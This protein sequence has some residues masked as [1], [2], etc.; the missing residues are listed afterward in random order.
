[1]TTGR[2]ESDPYGDSGDRGWTPRPA[3]PGW[4]AGQDYTGPL[5]DDTGWHIDL[6]DVDWGD[7][8]GSDWGDDRA[9]GAG[10]SFRF[11]N[12]DPHGGNG[13]GPATAD[14]DRAVESPDRTGQSSGRHA[15]RGRPHDEQAGLGRR[16][17]PRPPGAPRRVPG[18]PPPRA[19]PR[20]VVPSAYQQ[21]PTA[22]PR[23]FDA[24]PFDAPPYDPGP[25]DPDGF[26]PRQGFQAPPYPPRGYQ[27]PAWPPSSPPLTT[28]PVYEEPGY[29]ARRPPSARPSAGPPSGRLAGARAGAD[30]GPTSVVRSSGV[31]A[32]GTLGSRLT[33]FAR[34]L[35]QNFALGAAGIAE[36]YNL[37]NTLP[38]VVYNLALGGILTSVIVPLI[39]TASRRDSDRGESLRPADVHAGY[40]RSARHHRGRDAGRRADRAPVQGQPDHRPH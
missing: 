33:G 23:P 13:A 12:Q 18:E 25:Y 19:Q 27:P 21:P 35:V 9:A 17:V 29:G 40:G 15:R 2:P 7:D 5:F 32:A 4:T 34:T 11:S 3:V 30:G 31:M 39:V 1:M 28:P 22:D 10:A 37:S 16:T 14:H 38:N 36:A 8:A 24:P 26:A 20:R 6:S